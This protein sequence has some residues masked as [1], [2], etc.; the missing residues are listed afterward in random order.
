MQSADGVVCMPCAEDHECSEIGPAYFCSSTNGR[1]T[2][3]CRTDGDCP[4]GL[5]CDTGLTLICLCR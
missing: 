2:K 1:C 3:G 4:S 5:K